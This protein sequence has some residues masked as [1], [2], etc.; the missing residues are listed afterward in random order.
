M[1]VWACGKSETSEEHRCPA[2]AISLIHSPYAYLKRLPFGG[3]GKREMRRQEDERT[4]VSLR[5]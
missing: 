3:G 1:R 2:R 4:P 5:V